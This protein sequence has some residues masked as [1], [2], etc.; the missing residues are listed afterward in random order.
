MAT[1]ERV[2]ASRARTRMGAATHT[3]AAVSPVAVMAASVA[4]TAA[5]VVVNVLSFRALL[6]AT[7]ARGSED[8]V[9]AAEEVLEGSVREVGA[10][11]GT[12]PSEDVGATAALVEA[13]VAS[14]ATLLA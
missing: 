13:P 2:E 10:A 9:G 4:G 7:V 11:E 1:L 6:A 14:V 12:G 3:A 8:G 5:A